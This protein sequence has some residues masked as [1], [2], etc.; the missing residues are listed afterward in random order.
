MRDEIA[1]TEKYRAEFEDKLRVL[2]KNIGEV[3][4]GKVGQFPYGWRRSAKGRTVWRILE[5]LVSQ[6]LEAQAEAIGLQEFAP[7]DS[8]VGVYDFSFRLGKSE[9]IFVNIK[10]SVVGRSTSKDDISKAE[11]LIAFLKSISQ[12]TLF[13]ATVEIE[14]LVDP[15]RIELRN[16]YVV[17]TIWLPDIYVNPSNNGNVQSAKYKDLSAAVRRSRVEFIELLEDR[18]AGARQKRMKKLDA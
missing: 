9:T 7:A 2:L 15:L 11:K 13:I 8:E 6:N 17:P 5:E 3:Q 10:S 1:T 14:F 4:I 16:C 12:P 18:V